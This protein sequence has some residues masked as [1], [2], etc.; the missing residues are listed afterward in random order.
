MDIPVSNCFSYFL[1]I[2]TEAFSNPALIVGLLSVFILLAF[3]ALIAAAEVGFF[4]LVPAQIETLKNNF[5]PKN[6]RIIHLLES[7]KKLLATIV[8]AHNLVNVG[9]IIISE[10]LFHELFNFAANP[11]LGFVVQVIVVTF[12]ILLIGEVIPKIYST[13]NALKTASLNASAT[14]PGFFTI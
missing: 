4:S 9:V 10:T 2:N 6:Q 14:K 11:T 8:V 5:T 13:Q 3:S 1:I 12:L 7:P